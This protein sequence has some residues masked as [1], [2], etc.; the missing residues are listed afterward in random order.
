MRFRLQKAPSL[1]KGLGVAGSADFDRARERNATAA[2]TR[3]A[4]PPT[5]KTNIRRVRACAGI[6]GI[7]G[8]ATDRQNH[9]VV[10]GRQK[11]S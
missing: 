11:L 6:G 4:L 3:P 1:Q 9:L 8:P 2:T 7:L 10:S 5:K